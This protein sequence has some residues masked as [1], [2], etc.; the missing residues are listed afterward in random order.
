MCFVAGKMWEKGKENEVGEENEVGAL[1]F[2]LFGT[3]QKYFNFD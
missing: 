2:L 1:H 3:S